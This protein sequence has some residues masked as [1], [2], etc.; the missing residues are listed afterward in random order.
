MEKRG[1]YATTSTQYGLVDIGHHLDQLPVITST[2]YDADWAGI[3]VPYISQF[4]VVRQSYIADFGVDSRIYW[5]GH[6]SPDWS[7]S[8]WRGTKPF[9]RVYDE[10]ADLR[11]YSSP[12]AS[13][14]RRSLESN[15]FF[16]QHAVRHL[17]GRGPLT[18]THPPLYTTTLYEDPYGDMT[19]DLLVYEPTGSTQHRLIGTSFVNGFPSS[20]SV[21]SESTPFVEPLDVLLKKWGDSNK[22]L[23]AYDS[24][25]PYVN[26]FGPFHPSDDF[27]V[28]GQG[29][30]GSGQWFYGDRVWGLTD[31]TIEFSNIVW[32]PGYY[33]RYMHLVM[34]ITVED[35]PYAIGEYQR[36]CPLKRIT[37]R[38]H[39]SAWAMSQLDGGIGPDGLNHWLVSNVYPVD[40]SVS[41]EPEPFPLAIPYSQRISSSS[42]RDIGKN[43][44]E[45]RYGVM[46]AGAAD[47]RPSSML[48]AADALASLRETQTNYLEVVA[49]AGQLLALVPGIVDLFKTARDAYNV[50]RLEKLAKIGDILANFQLLYQFGFKPTVQN[51]EDL[52]NIAAKTAPLLQQLQAPQTVK[53]KVTIKFD[54]VLGPM[55]LVTRTSARVNGLSDD[56]IA[57]VMG[58][59]SL[60]LVPLTSNLWDVVPWSWF[61]DYFTGLAQKLNVIDGFILGTLRGVQYCVHSYTLYDQA[62]EELLSSGINPGEV[63]FQYYFRE[64]SRYYPAIFDGAYDFTSGRGADLGIAASIL[65]QLLR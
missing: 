16:R 44:A 52:S 10:L 4:N 63:E 42:M 61:I 64:V 7:E 51:V 60:G 15:T 22:P 45:R 28:Y 38:V 32:Y 23:Q 24:D 46:K 49:E 31:R 20:F 12:L 3:N 34:T 37:Q 6:V 59:D 21:G 5:S 47:I 11:N 56:F 14:G 43:I 17:T 50:S 33:A 19:H 35:L 1:L 18:P 55:T 13:L 8:T 40:Y 62:N 54:H 48:S 9:S 25:V 57:K 53:G 30:V 2:A 26:R 41:I 29:Q 39:G 65:W 27:R 36:G 58:L